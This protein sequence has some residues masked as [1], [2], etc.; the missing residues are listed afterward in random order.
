MADTPPRIRI[1]DAAPVTPPRLARRPSMWQPNP[2]VAFLS[3]LNRYIEWLE[4][5]VEGSPTPEMEVY[6]D[7][8]AIA[9]FMRESIQPPVQ[10]Q[11]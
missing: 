8:R 4:R 10:R 3:H 7:R 2:E 9:I 6:R 5:M 11:E 1:P